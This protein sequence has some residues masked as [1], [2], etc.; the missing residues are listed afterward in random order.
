MLLRQN[1]FKVQQGLITYCL[2][3]MTIRNDFVLGY[4]KQTF[5]T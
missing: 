3:S 4:L 1:T 5:S 2:N